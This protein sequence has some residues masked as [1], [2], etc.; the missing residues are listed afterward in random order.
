MGRKPWTF[1][2][3][4]GAVLALVGRERDI[5]GR[6]IA[7]TLDITERS[8]LRILR[9]LEGAGYIQRSKVGRGNQYAVNLELPLRRSD[10]RDVFVRELMKV[11]DF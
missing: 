7:S 1:I 6:K 11:L 5:T 4:H 2:T 8:V 3:N 10:Q 9:D